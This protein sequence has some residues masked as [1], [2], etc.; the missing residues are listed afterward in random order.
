[1]LLSVMSTASGSTPLLS[2][3]ATRRASRSSSSAREA[4]S[5]TRCRLFLS[6]RPHS[7]S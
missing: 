6:C 1:M 5:R 4:F 7:G 2:R 3:R